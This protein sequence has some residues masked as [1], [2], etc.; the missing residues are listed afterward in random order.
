MKKYFLVGIIAAIVP[1]I[2]FGASARF[3]Q[4]VREKERKM[5]ELEKCMGSTKGLKIAGI[6]TLGLTA[7][8]VAVNAVEAKKIKDYDKSIEATKTQIEKTKTEI[9]KKNAEL[10]KIQ[11]DTGAEK[12]TPASNQANENPDGHIGIFKDFDNYCGQIKNDGNYVYTSSENCSGLA[13]GEWLLQETKGS[14]LCK[15]SGNDSLNT[16]CECGVNNQQT[17][18]EKFDNE[19]DCNDMCTVACIKEFKNT[20]L[21]GSYNIE[22]S[23]VS[24]PT[25]DKNS[26]QTTKN[27]TD[28]LWAVQCKDRGGTWDPTRHN[29]EDDT[30]PGVCV[31]PEE[32]VSTSAPIG[33]PKVT[34]PHKML[35]NVIVQDIASIN[36]TPGKLGDKIYIHGYTISNIQ[37]LSLHDNLYNAIEEFKNRCYNN[38][39]DPDDAYSVIVGIDED[40]LGDDSDEKYTENTVLPNLNQHIVSRCECND[41]DWKKQGDK[42]VKK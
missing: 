14:S 31:L 19:D 13:D 36:G 28:K 35:Q 42:C 34:E 27:Q 3:T 25:I 40:A 1:S 39:G 18:I 37:H 9:D 7:A 29:D 6:S 17:A 38:A 32:V 11:N 33:A 5:A 16:V 12:S 4:L 15:S 21:Q 2:C 26:K 22:N 8:G 20:N 24:T 30:I 23:S 41:Y 10:S